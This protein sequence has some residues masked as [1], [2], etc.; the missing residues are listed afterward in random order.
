MGESY[1]LI[2]GIEDNVQDVLELFANILKDKSQDIREQEFQRLIKVG[3]HLAQFRFAH[4]VP[5]LVD[6]DDPSQVSFLVAAG[7]YV[8]RWN[9]AVLALAEAR[10]PN[11]NKYPSVSGDVAKQD[12]NQLIAWFLRMREI[13]LANPPGTGFDGVD[14]GNLGERSY[15]GGR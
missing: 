10:K 15:T 4:P 14:R 9:G 7:D 8:V 6:P 1:D 11:Q 13:S 3:Q 2:A 12:W 5:V